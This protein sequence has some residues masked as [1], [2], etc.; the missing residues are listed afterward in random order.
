MEE[1]RAVHTRMAARA[2]TLRICGNKRGLLDL[3]E[4]WLRARLMDDTAMA[5]GTPMEERKGILTIGNV[6]IVFSV[7]G[8][9]VSFLSAFSPTLPID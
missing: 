8:G 9:A 1:M 2:V 5:E 6:L 4:I 3:A 7:L